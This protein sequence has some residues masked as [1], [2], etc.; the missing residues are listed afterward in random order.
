MDD[1]LL[2]DVGKLG[3]GFTSAYVLEK[4]DIGYG[5][6]PKL[7]FISTKLDPEYKREVVAL[8]KEFRDCFAWEYCEMPGLDQW[9]VEHQLLIKP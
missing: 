9:I 7:M 8:L 1:F 2:D 3:H 6:R 4:V 5:D